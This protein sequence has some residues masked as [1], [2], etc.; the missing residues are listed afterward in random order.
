[1]FINNGID[2]GTT[3]SGI[4]IY[5]NGKVEILKNPVGFKDTLPSVVAFRKNR[6]VVGEKALEL[7]KIAPEN[8][9][10]S[11]KR[12][13]GTDS[14]YFS[15]IEEDI[16]TPV[17]LSSL[18]LRE[19]LSFNINSE[20][21]SAVITI[22]ASFDTIQSNA[23]KEA[24]YR[25][26]LKEVVLLQEPI[27][28]CLA[29]SNELKSQIDT[30]EL[31]LV[32]DFGGGTF[33]AALVRIDETELKVIDH[34]GN[35]FLGGV[36]IDHAIVE[37]IFVPILEKELGESNLL[38]NLRNN[39]SVFYKKLNAELLFKAEQLKKE[40]SIS[41]QSYFEIDILEKE[42]FVEVE[43]TKNQIDQIVHPYF[44][45]SFELL[46]KLIKSNQIQFS[47]VSKIILVGGTTYIPY[48]RKQLKEKTKINVDS[49]IDP[50]TAVIVG[51]AY[52]AGTKNSSLEEEVIQKQE[53]QPKNNNINSKELDIQWHYET[54]S[55]DK[56]ELITCVFDK[57]IEGFFRI[58]RNDGGFDT[59][60]MKFSNKILEFV[61]LIEKTVNV[62]QI[63]IYD[64]NQNI[65]AEKTD[66]NI[67][68][69][70]YNVVGQPLPNDI[71]IEVDDKNGKTILE[72]IFKKNEILPLKKTIYKTIS[73]NILKN[74]D[75][76]LIIN[77]VEGDSNNLPA[78]NSNIG[79]IEIS[80]KTFAND[81]IRGTDI[82][83]GFEISESRDLSINLY[84]S[85]IELELH[86]NF[87]P[88]KKAVSIEKLKFDVKQ[89]IEETDKELNYTD[90]E[91]YEYLAKIK[92]ISNDLKEI[93]ND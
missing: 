10:A 53:S 66:I 9:Y 6:I 55:R 50:T 49:S 78:S 37:K 48:I 7:L 54:T 24:G 21:K 92:R 91:N 83:I 61:P 58:T 42:I 90:E 15:K 67:A 40:L 65:I 16:I 25:A 12:K 52:Y 32:Y 18:I 36:D 39:Q 70:L 3:N 68:C 72:K 35:N 71:S 45:Q 87:T 73:K 30:E 93:Y 47:D 89:I 62:F 63:K 33:D 1:M 31:W 11:F 44:E 17:Y 60:L 46:E 26:G 59:G 14:V 8:V 29:Y 76:K 22:P 85:S 4:G 19:L 81:L 79:Y 28:A 77:I 82:E 13:M 74:S 43:I 27:A 88:N 23:T 41:D 34:E 64:K 86:E 75:D 56:E 20:I 84:I 38:S 51:A 80:G 57:T 5:N 2:L 69:G